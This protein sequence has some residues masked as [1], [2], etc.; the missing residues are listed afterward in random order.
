MLPPSEEQQE[1]Q[2]KL[3]TFHA[4]AVATRLA[5]EEDKVK[6]GKGGNEEEGDKAQPIVA[7]N[8][9]DNSNE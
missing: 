1:E 8:G 6:G 7:D 9:N 3:D 4:N 2:A 5:V